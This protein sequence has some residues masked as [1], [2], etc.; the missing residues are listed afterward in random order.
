VRVKLPAGPEPGARAFDAED[1]L[2]ILDDEQGA[3][4]A[5]DGACPGQRE[6][7]LADRSEHEWRGH[8]PSLDCCCGQT[9]ARA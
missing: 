8:A 2:V 7:T 9:R 4:D 3:R 5:R 1:T 6:A